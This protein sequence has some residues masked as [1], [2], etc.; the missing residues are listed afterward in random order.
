MPYE[1][2]GI[3]YY[4]D[5][6]LFSTG[7]L[8]IAYILFPGPTRKVLVFVLVRTPWQVGGFLCRKSF[9]VLWVTTKGT[10]RFVRHPKAEYMKVKKWIKEN[11]LRHPLDENE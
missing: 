2:M 11:T 1:G 4:Y 5:V 6:W 9:D 10:W 7:G 8:L 3:W